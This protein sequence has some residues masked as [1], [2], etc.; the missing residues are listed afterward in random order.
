[1][2]SKAL[3]IYLKSGKAEAKTKDIDEWLN[4]VSSLILPERLGREQPDTITMG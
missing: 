3:V 2:E 4:L 1:M